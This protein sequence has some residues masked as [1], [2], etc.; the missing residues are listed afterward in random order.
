MSNLTEAAHLAAETVQWCS[1]EEIERRIAQPAPSQRAV[2]TQE[3]LILMRRAQLERLQEE[4]Q[5][6]LPS[7]TPC[8]CCTFMVFTLV[9]SLLLLILVPSAHDWPLYLHPASRKSRTTDA[10]TSILSLDTE[11]Y[12]I[13]ALTALTGP[14]DVFAEQNV[15]ATAPGSVYEKPQT[16]LIFKI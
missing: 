13:T 7:I 10:P 3:E 8:L 14:A 5:H 2:P 6:E 15:S 16:T 1:Q 12:D 9:M 11:D 4:A